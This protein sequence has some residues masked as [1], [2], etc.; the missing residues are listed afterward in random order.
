MDTG[1]PGALGQSQH[2]ALCDRR[3]APPKQSHRARASWYSSIALPA[4]VT[5]KDVLSKRT[6]ELTSL[7]PCVFLS[8]HAMHNYSTWC[9]GQVEKGRGQV[10]PN[11]QKHG[12]PARASTVQIC[13]PLHF[14]AL[15]LVVGCSMLVQKLFPIVQLCSVCSAFRAEHN[16]HSAQHVLSQ[17]LSRQRTSGCAAATAGER[18]NSF[19]LDYKDARHVDAMQLWSLKTSATCEGLEACKVA[20]TPD[21]DVAL[22][23]KNSRML[24]NAYANCS[25]HGRELFLCP[26]HG[27]A[28]CVVRHPAAT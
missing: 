8:Q 22:P 4:I 12:Q 7:S 1:R 3:P 11:F 10:C 2:D 17:Q 13:P 28:S 16:G 21:I 6:R 20:L 18:P 27:G 24:I 26:S 9:Y 23:S 25:L 14:L 5:H 15:V 19:V